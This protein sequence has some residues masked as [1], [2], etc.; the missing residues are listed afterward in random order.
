MSS[1]ERQISHTTVLV[2]SDNAKKKSIKRLLQGH[3][4]GTNNNRR[5]IVFQS[6]IQ[7]R[8]SVGE[9]K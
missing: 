6:R 4:A 9:E 1:W 5:G 3:R 7:E 8:F 2:F